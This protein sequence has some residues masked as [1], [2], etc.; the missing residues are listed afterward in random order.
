MSGEL[1]LIAKTA[2]RL[3]LK[4][5][6][7]TQA[8]K[9]YVVIGRAAPV[10]G[11]GRIKLTIKVGK[12]V[13]KAL[14]KQKNVQLTLRVTATDTARNTTVTTAPVRLRNR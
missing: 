10:S 5:K 9:R 3:K 7:L 11:N 1:L 2:A 6:S 4:G 14:G 8:G 12:A 13:R